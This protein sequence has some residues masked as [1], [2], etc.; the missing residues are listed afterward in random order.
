MKSL[1]FNLVG[2]GI[3][4]AIISLS[5]P[6]FANGS[7]MVNPESGVGVGYWCDGAGYKGGVAACVSLAQIDPLYHVVDVSFMKVYGAA[8]IIPTFQLDPEII[9]LVEQYGSTKIPHDKLVFGISTNIDAAA[10]GFINDPQ[11]LYAAFNQLKQPGQ[12]LRGVMTW[13]INWDMGQNC[14]GKT[15]QESFIKA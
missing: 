9:R 15:Y 14:A 2:A 3:A 4:L 12:P 7:D 1:T 8:G 11:K 10:T 6:T 13:S 5:A